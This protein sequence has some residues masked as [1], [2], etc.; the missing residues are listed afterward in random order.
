VESYFVDD[1]ESDE[2][3]DKENENDEK[4]GNWWRQ[5]LYFIFFCHFT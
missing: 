1:E 3:S 5:L 2:E 4:S